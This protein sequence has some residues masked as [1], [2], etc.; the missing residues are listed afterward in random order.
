MTWGLGSVQ[1]RGNNDATQNTLENGDVEM[2]LELNSLTDAATNLS[3][4]NLIMK[5]RVRLDEL[6]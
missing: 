2:G 4:L 3:V 1:K 6:V 5:G